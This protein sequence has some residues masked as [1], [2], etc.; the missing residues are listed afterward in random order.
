MTNSVSS[1]SQFIEATQFV[2]TDMHPKWK[3]FYVLLEDK[4]FHYLGLHDY[5]Q[6]IDSDSDVLLVTDTFNFNS[7][8]LTKRKI[9]M[10]DVKDIKEVRYLHK[11]KMI[12]D[13][14]Q[15]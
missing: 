2:L 8:S 13:S 6:F 10:V 9:H 4:D 3:G 15:F 1:K 11:G 12:M 7:I 5:E 14:I